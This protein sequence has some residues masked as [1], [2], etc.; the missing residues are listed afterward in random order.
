MKVAR[1]INIVIGLLAV[2]LFAQSLHVLGAAQIAAG[3]TKLGWGV[4]AILAVAGA[5]DVVRAIAWTLTV[6]QPARLGLLPALRA[7][8]AGEALNTLLPMGVVV[9]E[10]TKASHVGDHLPFGAAARALAIEFAFY[11]ASL[12]P[13]FAAGVAAFAI[14]NR[15]TTGVTPILL[16]EVAIVIVA[17]LLARRMLRRVPALRANR[18]RR[19]A[20]IAA[21][22]TAYQ[23]FAVAEVYL[24]LSLINPQHSTIASALVLE[25]VNRGVTMFF[26]MI[27]MRVGIDEASSS[28]VAPYVRLDPA[29]GLTLALVRKLR[30]LFWSAVGLALLVRRR[31]NAVSRVAEPSVIAPALAIV[32]ALFVAPRLSAQEAGAVVS[33]SV[34]IAQP[35]GPPVVVPGVTVTLRCGSDEPRVE[36]SN[37]QGAFTFDG[38]PADR[39]ACSIGAEL[40][41]FSSAARTVQVAAGQTTVANLQLGL[42]TLREE[43]TVRAAIVPVD[44]DRSAARAEQ[45]QR[46]T[47]QA[48]PIAQDRYQ[49]ALPLIPGVVRGPDGLLNISGLRSNQG[50]LTFN[51]ANGTDP[52]TGEDAIELPIDAVSSVQVRGAA[53]APEYGLSAGAITVVETAKASDAWDVTVNDLEP[54]LRRR[55]GEFHG[56][57]SWTPRVTVGGPIVTGKVQLLESVQYEYSQTRVFGLPPSESDT[58]LVSFES[59]TRADWLRGQADR[60]T[61]SILVSPRKTTYAGLNTFNPQGVTADVRTHNVLGS[62]TDQIVL[63]SG[64]VD[65][66]MSVKQFDTTINPSRG[67]EPMVLAP[68]VNSGSY[69]NDQDRTSR[70]AEW[71][72]TYSF[73][74]IGPAHLVKA[75]GGVTYETFDGS[76]TSRPVRIVREDGTL[77]QLIAFDGSGSLDR[78]KIAVRGFVQDG[79][80]VGSRLTLLYGA[81]YDRESIT[82]G[83]NVSPRGSVS[84]AATS[85]GRTIVRGGGGVFYNAVPLNVASFGQLQTRTVT[86]FGV[87]GETPVGEVALANVVASDVRAP[88]SVTWNVEIDRELFTKLFVRAGYQ[89]RDNHDENYVDADDE[90]IVLR[91]DGRSRY[92]EAQVTTRYTFHGDDRIVASYTRSS[93]SGNLNDYNGYFGNIENP[94]IRPD[95]RGPLPWDAPNRVLIWSSLTLPH[96]FT[97]FPVL[98]TR[99]GFPLSYVDADR[100]FV[101]PRNRVGRY[102]T[103]VSLDAQIAKKFRVFGHN[104]T[105]GLKV[106]NITDH[107]N[108]RD[109]QGNTASADFGGFNNAVGRTFRGKWVFEF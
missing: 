17:G 14:A 81:R 56:I 92:R 66:R 22:E 78:H 88:R 67:L 42:D 1:V 63:E 94:V 79:W 68:D 91:S 10:P 20:V 86:S 87:D 70:R 89:E 31:A 18:P 59:F 24:T 85:D 23:V 30:M 51:N 108:P 41:G 50:A 75:G 2:A 104:A 29:T 97:V 25:S 21:C 28:F 15:M 57:E 99:T 12:V 90:A 96:G 74:P 11:G 103:F 36:M 84:L 77:S 102:P 43:V 65:T 45:L 6:E 60:V 9:G 8:L 95:Q 58:Q 27:P 26:K 7:R 53:Y 107:F 35:D 52:V 40:E 39:R 3:L 47:M 80:T 69:F 44:G 19:V 71:L 33:G 62:V 98:D 101:G 54:R 72:T 38:V 55:G 73:T 5:R 4:L 100:N 106:F 46:S 76:S 61:A 16:A 32:L 13:L 48:A 37:A 49:D 34:A 93:A 83:V 109:F 64:V 105:I 82:S